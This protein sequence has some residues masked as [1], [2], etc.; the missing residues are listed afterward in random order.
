MKELNKKA[1]LGLAV[2][3]KPNM[4]FNKT[5]YYLAE[6]VFSGLQHLYF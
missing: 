2:N 4:A 5:C 3:K 1:F 6:S